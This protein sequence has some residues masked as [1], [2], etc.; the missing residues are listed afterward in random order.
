[1]LHEQNIRPTL[2]LKPNNPYDLLAPPTPLWHQR[3]QVIDLLRDEGTDKEDLQV[4]PNNKG[5]MQVVGGN[6]VTVDPADTK[7]G[8]Y[9]SH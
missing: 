4:K 6:K 8:I 7:V 9:V 3:E 5:V 2:K 1:M